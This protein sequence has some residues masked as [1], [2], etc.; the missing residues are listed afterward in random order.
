MKR[1]PIKSKD[2]HQPRE[3]VK[4]SNIQWTKIDDV[5]THSIHHTEI[6]FNF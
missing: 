1:S 2:L 3:K 5:T 4:H 6:F